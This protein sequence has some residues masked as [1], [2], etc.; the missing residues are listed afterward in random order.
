MPHKWYRHDCCGYA[1]NSGAEFCN[2]CGERGIPQPG[3]GLSSVEHICR[4]IKV[5]GL[6]PFGPHRRFDSGVLENYL[7]CKPCLATGVIDHP[8]PSRDGDYGYCKECRGTG[9]V[10]IGTPESLRSARKAL[11]EQFPDAA[12]GQPPAHPDLLDAAK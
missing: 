1:C 7:Y 4:Y 12:A 8:D 5:T 10:F 11:L 2:R 6:T 9:Y 3:W